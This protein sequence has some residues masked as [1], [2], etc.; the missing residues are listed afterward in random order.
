MTRILPRV[1][2]DLCRARMAGK[3]GGEGGKTEPAPT[4]A[5]GQRVSSLS[6][7]SDNGNNSPS[8]RSSTSSWSASPNTTSQPPLSNRC[9]QRRNRC[10]NNPAN[11]W[12][13]SPLVFGTRRL[14]GRTAGWLAI[15]LVCQCALLFQRRGSSGGCYCPLTSISPMNRVIR[16]S[17][18]CYRWPLHGPLLRKGCRVWKRVDVSA[19]M[20]HKRFAYPR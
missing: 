1:P 8:S 12:V 10:I 20:F 13:V 16:W 15:C 18:L 2:Q 4:H 17:C 5:Q 3:T 6:R 7:D 9:S 19:L 11:G 14:F